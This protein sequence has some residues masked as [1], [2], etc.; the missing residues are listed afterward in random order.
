VTDF[1]PPGLDQPDI[2]GRIGQIADELRSLARNGLHY[3]TNP[4]D[5]E[6]Y[7]RIQRL[8][9]ELMASVDGRSSVDIGRIFQDDLG[10][11]TPIVAVDGA[12]FD[13]DDRL[14]LA[15]RVDSGQWCMPGGAAD[16]GEAPSAGAEREVL[17]E[18]GLRVRATR[19]VGVFDNRTWGYL[20]AVHA[21][22]LVF[23]CA[24]LG[25]ELTPSIETTDFRWVTEP[26]ATALPLYRSHVYKVPEAFR[27]RRLPDAPT[28]FH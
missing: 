26:E 8:S 22:Y 1:P 7:Q 17:E 12:V 6:R 5:I 18:T 28:S 21:Y 25:G 10:V 23:E 24:V 14:L 13:T 20:G 19:I 4:Y 3:G 2:A 11:R 15:Q 9:A 16:V 27:L